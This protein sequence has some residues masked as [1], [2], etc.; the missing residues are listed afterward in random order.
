MAKYLPC[1]SLRP[2]ILDTTQMY[3]YCLYIKPVSVTGQNHNV[4][5]IR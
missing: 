1:F 3:V 2:L 4:Y 5:D